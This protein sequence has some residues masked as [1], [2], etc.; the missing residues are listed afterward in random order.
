MFKLDFHSSMFVTHYAY[1]II[2][3]GMFFVVRRLR[4]SMETVAEALEDMVKERR[5]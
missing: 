5:R 4:R 1:V 2:A 3:V